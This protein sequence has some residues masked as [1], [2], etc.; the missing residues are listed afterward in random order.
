VK[1]QHRLYVHYT[2]VILLSTLLLLHPSLVGAD[3]YAS[4]LG[5]PT[6]SL[7]IPRDV[8]SF[9]SMASAPNL[10][11]PVNPLPPASDRSTPLA[12]RQDPA[13]RAANVDSPSNIVVHGDNLTYDPSPGLDDGDIVTVTVNACDPAVPANCMNAEVHPFAVQTLPVIDIWY[14]SHQS[15]GYI[16]IPQQWINILGNVSDPD[17]IASLTYSL[18]GGPESSLSIGPDTR[19]LAAEGDFNVDIAYTDLISGSNQIVITATDTL[20]NT[21]IETVTVDYTSGNT[22][23]I[24]YAIDW[25]SVAAIPDV[26]QIVDGL[27]TL[28][29]NS[30]RPVEL[31]YDRLVA[32]GD[33]SW[34]DYEIAVPVTI[35][36][37]DP[38]GYA[39]PS[40]GP[41]VG[42]LMRWTGH[43]D[44][45][46][47]GWQPKSGYLPLGAIG[48]YRWRNDSLGD[49]LQMMGGD[50]EIVAED[51]SGRKLEYDTRYI[52]KMRVETIAGQ[53]GLYSFKVW[54]EGQPEPSE[55]DLVAQEGLSNLQNGSLMLLAHHVD[56]S[57]GDVTI[58]PS[59]FDQ[60]V[61]T[62]AVN[63][64][65]SGSVTRDPDQATY[66]YGQ[67]VT[68]TA[69]ADPGWSFAG[70]SGDLG[71][72]ITATVT[73]TGNTT[74]TATFDQNEYALTVNTDGQGTVAVDPIP[75]PYHYGDVVTLT[76]SADPG[77]S[78]AGWSGD[79][80]T[81]TTATVTMTGNTT[82]TATFVQDE[83]TL[84]VDTDGQGTVAV[85]PTP[86]PYHYGDVV[87][88]TASADPGWSFAG[89][90]G[91]L[92]TDVTATVTITGDTTITAT[93]VQHEYALT[94]NIDGQGTV[95]VDP[96]PG[97]YH[98]GDVVT[99]TASADP[100]WS[101]AHWSGDLGTG[102]TATVTVTGSTTVTATFVQDEYALTVN[103]DGQGTVAVDPKPGPY[104][105]GDVV[106]LTATAD[107]GWGFVDWS[108]GL[109]TSDNPTNLIMTG[110]TVV[111]ATFT[112]SELDTY[113]LFLPLIAHQKSQVATLSTTNSPAS[114]IGRIA[115]DSLG[116]G[117]GRQH[118][119][120]V[121]GHTVALLSSRVGGESDVGRPRLPQLWFSWD[122]SLLQAR[123]DTY[124]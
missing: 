56:A 116:A 118:A 28:E 117:V 103:I 89:W 7:T 40:N 111:T 66:A 73:I 62:L 31:G 61:Y 5:R 51:T 22:W 23:P 49:R 84:T 74:V 96:I 85:D 33:V 13:P 20:D 25:S 21:T 9:T 72:G 91:D 80:G 60:N 93:F 12:A 101:F 43:T 92:G 6:H 121:S 32:M 69:S 100:G 99:L 107:V 8:L 11:F 53:G 38:S 58:T 1:I 108:G 123:E 47:Y 87:T 42:I 95:A 113:Q 57:F 34:D 77:W 119:P 112:V 44:D 68:L 65:G 2:V 24:P 98:Y 10:H 17:G 30:I 86:G 104:H 46:I 35:H 4:D 124:T 106:T 26:A 122:V 109:S 55:W 114:P 48:M 63:T 52:F 110:N 70:W 76:A 81:G 115:T 3:V 105:H 88:L 67:V 79:L 27:W 45:P 14:G 39:Y 97:P 59:P 120:A 50:G 19:R 41:V 102:I 15:F 82:V 90:S 37:I 64:S 75:G 18:N 94:V 78:F 29:A 71:T 54:E 83:Y 16:G 36:D